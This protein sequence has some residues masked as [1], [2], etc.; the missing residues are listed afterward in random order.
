MSLRCPTCPTPAARLM[1]L[2]SHMGHSTVPP[3]AQVSRPEWDMW[4]IT[5]AHSSPG[6]HHPAGPAAPGPGDAY[7]PPAQHAD[8]R[9]YRPASQRHCGPAAGTGRHP[10]PPIET[11]TE[12]AHARIQRPGP[13]RARPGRARL[14][15][16]AAVP[17]QQTAARQLSAPAAPGTASPPT[18]RAPAP[19]WPRAGG[20]TASAPPPPTPRRITAW[21][22]R[23]PRAVPGVAAGPSGLVLVDIDAH[24]GPPPPNLATGLLPGIDLAAEPIPRDAWDDPARFRDGRDTLTLLAR[25]R[26]GPRPWPPAPSTSRSPPPPPPAGRTCG[27][28]RPPPTCARPS[29][30]PTAGTGWPGKSTSKPDGPTA[31]PPAP[32]PRPAATGY[33]AA[34]PPSPAACPPGSP[35][36]SSAPPP[37]HH[38]GPP[39]RRRYPGPAGPARPPTS[40]PS[41]AAAPP[42]SPP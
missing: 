12:Y 40:P 22:R 9:P 34:T 26:G 39:P 20:A 4:D 25:L 35:A 6:C 14:A 5:R 19:A 15:H 38:A 21:W 2:M 29:P 17:G 23:E 36:R 33:A 13:A 1:S 7:T 24:G 18:W 41:S 8:G 3:S 16:P 10:P 32:P 27:T 31:S 11:P 37:P 28:R 42:S 30:T